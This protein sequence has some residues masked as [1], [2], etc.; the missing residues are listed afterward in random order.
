MCDAIA[1]KWGLPNLA[2]KNTG[3]TA[4]FENMIN[5]NNLFSISM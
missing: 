4:K 3:C 2:K 1:I 5:N